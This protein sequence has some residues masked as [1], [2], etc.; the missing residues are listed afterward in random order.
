[1]RDIPR[2][3]IRQLGERGEDVFGKALIKLVLRNTQGDDQKTHSGNKETSQHPRQNPQ[4]LD[5]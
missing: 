4:R 3:Q 5:Q 2:L 1:L